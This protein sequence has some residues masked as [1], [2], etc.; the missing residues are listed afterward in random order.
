VTVAGS[1]ADYRRGEYF[2]ELLNVGNG[3]AAVWQNVSVSTSGGGSASGNVFVPKS[4][5]NYTYDADGNT[6]ADGRWSY[7]FD[8]EN[9]LISIQGIAGLPTGANKKLDFEYDCQGRR[10]SKKLYNWNGF[11]YVLQYHRKFLYDGW[12]LVAEWDGLAGTLVRSYMW[13]L[14]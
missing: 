14:D 7:T 8:A 5:E 9:R 10:I 2:Q 1:A 12:N 11:S 6:T 3:S 4:P 13:G